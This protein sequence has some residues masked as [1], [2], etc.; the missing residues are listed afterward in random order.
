MN[1]NEQL[2]RDGAGLLRAAN[3]ILPDDQS[4]VLLVID[5]FEEI[6]T[7][8]EDETERQHFLELLLRAINDNRSRVRVVVTLRADYYDRPLQYPEFGDL[9]RH[10]VET[11]LPLS[12]D[13]LEHAIRK[14]A[15]QA[16]VVFEDGLVSQI[17]SD[18]HYQAGALPLLQYALTELF[19]RRDDR[20]LTHEAYQEVGGTGG[21]LAK[22]ADDIYLEADDESQELIRQMMLRLVTLGEGAEDA[23]RRAERAEMLEIAHDPEVMDEIIDLYARSRLL[24]LDHDPATR[25]PTVE[26]AHEAILRE[27]D[28]LRGWLNDSREDIRQERA[29]ARAA[30][31]WYA[32]VEDP[33][34]LLT[35]SRLASAVA[36]RRDTSLTITPS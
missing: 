6:F 33:S 16:S 23:R 14:P 10:R 30:A 20:R 18:V 12:A 21:A 32:N 7:L 19:E 36:W 24:A 3:L 15:E 4:E 34:Y 5:Q 11:V 25:R 29:F 2:K 17:V 9:M 28:R 35:G 8:V 31:E 27:W 1:L 22:R 26:V 13:E